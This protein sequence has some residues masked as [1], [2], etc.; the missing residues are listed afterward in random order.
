MLCQLREQRLIWI[1]WSLLLFSLAENCKKNKSNI[2]MRL[3]MDCNCKHY[4][5]TLDHCKVSRRDRF[6]FSTNLLNDALQKQSPSTRIAIYFYRSWSIK[7][8]SQCRASDLWLLPRWDS[9]PHQQPAGPLSSALP[10]LLRT[11]LRRSPWTAA[12][13]HVCSSDFK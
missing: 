9:L 5:L 13:S 6:F 12:W 7:P 10:R 2:N 3:L 8:Q 1:N 11:P 4:D